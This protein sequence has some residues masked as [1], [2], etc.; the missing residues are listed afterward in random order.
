MH[1][2]VA[3]TSL[4]GL[5]AASKGDGRCMDAHVI[6]REAVNAYATG[7]AA[8]IGSRMTSVAVGRPSA[9][10]LKGCDSTPSWSCQILY[11]N[12]VLRGF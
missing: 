8:G 10:G 7:S 5:G 3:P 12:V 4:G 2:S 1:S 11:V 6:D 9:S